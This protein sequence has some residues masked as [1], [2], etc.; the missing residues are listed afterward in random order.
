MLYFFCCGS[1]QGKV[2]RPA[3]TISQTLNQGKWCIFSP[4]FDL[5]AESHG[6][7]WFF[8]PISRL[9]SVQAPP[10]G[11]DLEERDPDGRVLPDIKEEWTEKN[12]WWQKSWPEYVNETPQ[13]SGGR[14]SGQSTQDL[15]SLHY[16]TGLILACVPYVGMVVSHPSIRGQCRAPF[17]DHNNMEK[18]DEVMMTFLL[19]QR[20]GGGAVTEVVC[21]VVKC[22]ANSSSSLDS[23]GVT[24]Q[25]SCPAQ[26]S[27]FPV[28]LPRL[29]HQALDPQGLWKR[30]KLCT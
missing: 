9:R 20:K 16:V 4:V 12:D 7:P 15:S 29:L 14:S 10:L 27:R 8:P 22:I 3:L 18:M 11:L 6:K 24:H 21:R 13:T 23:L 2:G 28:G 19:W 30:T 5:I 26:P 17:S 1:S 25:L